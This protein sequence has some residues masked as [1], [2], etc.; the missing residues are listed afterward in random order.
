MDDRFDFILISDEI[1]FGT[2]NVLYLQESYKAFG[3][4]GQRFN[5]SINSPPANTAVSQ[6]IS[7]A[8]LNVSD[9]LPIVLQLRVDKVLQTPEHSSNPFMA[10]IYPMPVTSEMNVSFYL[11][12]PGMVKFEILDAQ[13]RLIAAEEHYFQ[14]GKQ[15]Y[16]FGTDQ[17]KAGFYFVRMRSQMGHSTVLRLVKTD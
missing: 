6:E 8:L 12:Q 7:E 10:E 2:R 4:D 3:Q 1:R 11:Q 5:S 14:N 9:H 13:G 17:L 16:S 15:V